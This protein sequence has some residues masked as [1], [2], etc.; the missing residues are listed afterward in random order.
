MSCIPEIAEADIFHWVAFH[1]LRK[2]SKS[3]EVSTLKGFLIRSRCFDGP[4][5][6]E[7]TVFHVTK[8][9]ENYRKC[10]IDKI[11]FPNDTCLSTK[12]EILAEIVSHFTKIFKNKPSPDK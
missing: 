2:F 5:V 7:D 4:E 12:E 9:R 1:Q 3:W 6:E 8:A 11:I 10:C